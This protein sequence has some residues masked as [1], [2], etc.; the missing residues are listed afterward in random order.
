M[1]CANNHHV[2]AHR[3]VEE[4]GNHKITFLQEADPYDMSLTD[5]PTNQYVNGIDL[6]SHCICA[7]L[8][9]QMVDTM[10]CIHQVADFGDDAVEPQGIL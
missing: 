1:L 4:T 5:M 2:A 3:Y 6:A 10:D 8:R 9:T 7:A